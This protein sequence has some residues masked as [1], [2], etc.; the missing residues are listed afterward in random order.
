MGVGSAAWIAAHSGQCSSLSAVCDP[1]AGACRWCP[2][3]PGRCKWAAWAV[4]MAPNTIA[5][6]STI[7][8]IQRIERVSE[9]SLK[10]RG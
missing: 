5:K 3:S 10:L 9:R 7:H 2:G 1:V 8:R 4:E 6:A